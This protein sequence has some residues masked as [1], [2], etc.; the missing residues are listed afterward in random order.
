MAVVRRVLLA[1]LFLAVTACHS[2]SPRPAANKATSVPPVATTTGGPSTTAGPQTSGV[3]TVL[4]PIGLNIRAQAAKTAPVLGTAARAT[5]LTV[6][7][8]TV[9]G[10]GWFQVKGATIT[11]WISDNPTLSSSGPSSVY[12]SSVVGFS[13]LYPVGWTAAEVPPA[14]VVFKGVSGGETVTVTAAATVALLGKPGAGYQQ[15]KAEAMVVC[16]VTADM[17]TYAQFATSSKGTEPPIGTPTGRYL[18]QVH[19]ALDAQRALGIDANLGDQSQLQ[20]VRDFAN[21]VTFAA[22]HCQQ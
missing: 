11:G 13:A 2:S 14:S 8:H 20:S 4:S 22:P 19:F 17:I 3:R 10:G 21:S 12:N 1:T 5:K 9:D 18:A 15:T 16:G 6:L 7:G